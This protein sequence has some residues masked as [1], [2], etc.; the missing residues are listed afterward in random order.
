M[1]SDEKKVA[2]EDLV[3]SAGWLMFKEYA[4][5]EWGPEGYGR[6]VA[7]VIALHQEDAT[8][9]AVELQ[10]VHYAAER[11]NEVMRWAGEQVEKLQPVH[12]VAERMQRGGR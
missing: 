11:V 8:K 5:K 7:G 2:M 3:S 9:L 10:K 12:E 4:R 6:K 1:N